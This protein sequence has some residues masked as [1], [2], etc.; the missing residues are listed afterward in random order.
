LSTKCGSLDVSQP[1]EPPRPVTG[2][3]LP[4]F[5]CVVGCNLCRRAQEGDENGREE[6]IEKVAKNRKIGKEQDR[7]R[8]DEVRE[9]KQNT[10]NSKEQTDIENRKTQKGGGNRDRKKKKKKK[11]KYLHTRHKHCTVESFT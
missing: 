6:I 1:Y 3:P 2:I 7:T 8:S 10:T 11:K 5:T 4:T 9:L